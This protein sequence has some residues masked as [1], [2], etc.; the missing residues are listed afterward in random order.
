MSDELV[1]RLA[2]LDT[3]AVSDAMTARGVEACAI[4]ISSV[5]VERRIAGRAVTVLLGSPQGDAPRR[6]LC[7]GAVDASGPG[8]VIVISGSGRTDTASWGGTLSMAAARNGIAGVVIDG[9]C[10]DVDESRDLGLPVYARAGVPRTAR[11]RI[12]EHDWNCPI[13]VGGVAVEP[14]D[15]VLADGSGVVFVPA[16]VA[17]EVLDKAETIAAKER[18]M[19]ERIRNGEP[20]ADVMSGDYESMLQQ[21]VGR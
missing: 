5:T 9:A 1:E 20:V 18:L 3:C 14:G 15:L 19:A 6:H 11:G 2:A 12:V 10:R 21:G 7:T 13:E 16:T 17:A 4:G 8:D